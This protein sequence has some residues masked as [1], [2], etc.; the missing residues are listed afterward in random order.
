MRYWLFI[1]CLCVCVTA[2]SQTFW[3]PVWMKDNVRMT[4]LSGTGNYLYINAAGQ[5]SKVSGVGAAGVTGLSNQQVLYGKSDGTIDQEAAFTYDESI[6]ML[7][8]TNGV[9]F[10]DGT[11]LNDLTISESGFNVQEFAAGVDRVGELT[12]NYLRFLIDGNETY[13]Y[14]TSGGSDHNLYLPNAQGG[15][16]TFLKNDGSGNLSWSAETFAGTVTSVALA[17][18]TS[19]SDVNI[20]GSPITG[21]GTITLNIPDASTTAR[22]LVTTGAQDIAGAKTFTSNI[23]FEGTADANE[24][25]LAITDPT[26]DNTVTVQ[27]ITGTIPMGVGTPVNLTAQ[28][29][30]IAATTL[31]AVPADGF[32][33]VCWNATVTRAATTSSTLGPFQIRYTNVPDNVVKTWP[34]ANV[35]NVNQ[36][37]TNSTA[38]GV[39]AGSTTVYARSGTNIQYI[40]G[41]TSSGATSMQYELNI[42]VIKI[43]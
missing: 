13:I 40:M 5:L 43:R 21:S 27:N 8:M 23:L 32:Y 28:G 6:N 39:I 26:A 15:A 17:A 29:A 19:G 24:T 14:R 25:T 1:F 31:Y 30:S 4:G 37:A 33:Q 18:G 10:I 38:S 16:N 35:N 41:Y 20:T 42:T 36:A 12:P 9:L 3:S 34:S 11:G 22:G 2:S 7:S